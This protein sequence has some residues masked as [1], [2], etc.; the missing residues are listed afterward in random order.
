[1]RHFRLSNFAEISWDHACYLPR[2]E[3]HKRVAGRASSSG[4]ASLNAIFLVC[5]SF[6]HFG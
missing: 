5:F 2:D 6:Y 3:N 4:N 1:M